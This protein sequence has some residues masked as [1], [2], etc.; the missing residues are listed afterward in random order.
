MGSGASNDRSYL[1]GH[2]ALGTGIAIATFVIVMVFGWPCKPR[3]IST[4]LAY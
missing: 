4:P 2:T 3:A 1:Q